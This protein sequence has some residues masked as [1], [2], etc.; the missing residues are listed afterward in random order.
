MN[1]PIFYPLLQLARP[2]A[3]SPRRRVI[4]PEV[5][6][7]LDSLIRSILHMP[8]ETRLEL[9]EWI[10]MDSRGVPHSVYV[11]VGTGRDRR[12]FVIDKASERI[13]LAD[14]HAAFSW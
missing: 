13:A 2:P 12:C 7:K 4:D 11:H 9:S 6:R 5:A 14:V 3:L 8:A 10:S 1:T